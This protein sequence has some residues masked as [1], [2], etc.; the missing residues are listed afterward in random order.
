MKNNNK[1]KE[2]IKKNK[3]KNNKIKLNRSLEHRNK[4]NINK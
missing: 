2:N 3:N 1:S 4:Y